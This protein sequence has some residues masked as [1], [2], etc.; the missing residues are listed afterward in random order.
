MRASIHYDITYIRSNLTHS[1]FHTITIR[2][3]QIVTALLPGDTELLMW[4]KGKYIILMSLTH[5]IRNN[6]SAEQ[7]M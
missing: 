6:T 5:G 7:I 3:S 2:H 1:V 4:Q